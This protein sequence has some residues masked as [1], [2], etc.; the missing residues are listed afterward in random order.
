MKTFRIWIVYRV[1][2]SDNITLT[3]TKIYYHDTYSLISA[4]EYGLKK[5]MNDVEELDSICSIEIDEV[6]MC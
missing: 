4:R 1:R 2:V 3:K 6:L 5:F